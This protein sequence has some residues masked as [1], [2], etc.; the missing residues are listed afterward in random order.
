MRHSGRLDTPSSL[1]PPEEKGT[2]GVH[3]RGSSRSGRRIPTTLDQS[4]PADGHDLI[5]LV[6]KAHGEQAVALSDRRAF[7]REPPTQTS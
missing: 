4:N 5:R 2:V 1:L 6:S 3:D 7:A